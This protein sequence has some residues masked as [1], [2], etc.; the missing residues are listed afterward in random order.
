[1][2]L[3]IIYRSLLR[4]LYRGLSLEGFYRDSGSG[5]REQTGIISGC[6]A[7]VRRVLRVLVR[8]LHVH[9]SPPPFLG[10]FVRSGHTIEA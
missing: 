8:V 1:M 10:Q 9:P 7:C 4:G 6:V 2:I 3:P 5:Y